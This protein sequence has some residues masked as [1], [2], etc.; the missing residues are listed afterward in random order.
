MM[1]IS[2]RV[3]LLCL[4]LIIIGCA[5]SGDKSSGILKKEPG[6]EVIHERFAMNPSGS[7]ESCIELQPG[8]VFDYDFDASDSVHFNIH[9]HGE[10]KVHKPVDK[11]WVTFG[12]GMVDPA[13]HAFYNEEQEFY[14]L[15]WDNPGDDRVEV[16]FTCTLK[17]MKANVQEEK[18]KHEGGHDQDGHKH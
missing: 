3:L 13:T 11:S 12:K 18:N 10:D 4:I 1:K 6:G 7:Y 14:C 8:M 15:M 9:Y 17:Q 5:A 16:S 2:G